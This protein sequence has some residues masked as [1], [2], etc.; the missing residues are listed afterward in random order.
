MGWL[1][2]SN[3]LRFYLEWGNYTNIL[4]VAIRE[5]FVLQKLGPLVFR[6]TFVKMK[7]TP[8]RRSV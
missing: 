1:T 2:L 8:K 3:H 7:L 5:E 6:D 4:L